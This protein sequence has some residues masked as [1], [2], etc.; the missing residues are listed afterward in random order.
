MGGR[1]ICALV[2]TGDDGLTRSV[3]EKSN[4]SR[5]LTLQEGG[6]AIWL[7]RLEAR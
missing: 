3:I 6:F 2:T 5:R 1:K 7:G 4:I